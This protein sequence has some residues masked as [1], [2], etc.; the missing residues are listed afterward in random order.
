MIS[1]Y[2][3][4]GTPSPPMAAAMGSAAERQLAR[5]PTVNSRLISKPTTR[6][7]IVSKPS[8]TQ[9]TSDSRNDASPTRKPKEDSQNAVNRG[10]NGEFVIPTASTV[11]RS[12]STPADGAQRAKSSAADRI[13]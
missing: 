8:F 13:R 7:K 3:S 12:N 10:P 9:L 6:K 2:N 11:A 4:T 1:E 5:W